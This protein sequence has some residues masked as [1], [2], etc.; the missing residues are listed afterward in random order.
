MSLG[1]PLEDRGGLMHISAADQQSLDLEGY[2]F[3]P[4]LMGDELLGRLRA[5]V[6]QLFD[7]E[8]AQAGS[9]FKQEPGCRRLANL[10]NKGAVFQEMILHSIVLELVESVLGDRF[11]L[12]SLNARQVLPGCDQPQPL[13]ADM[14]AIPDEAGFWVC[15]TIWML[16]DFTSENGAPRIVPRSHRFNALPAERIEDLN[17]AHPDEKVICGPAGSVIVMNAHAWHGGMPNRTD[18]SRTAVHAFYARWDKP[19]Q[20]YQRR[21]LDSDLQASF[22]PHLRQLLALDDSLNDELSAGEV[23]RSGFMK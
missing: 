12:S 4:N 9:E 11:K 7:R 3:L 20:Q 1:A 14:A 16:D 15:N 6:G 23:V 2:L 19:Q 8:G 21:L 22:S 10:V 13:H 17:A 5:A 18:N